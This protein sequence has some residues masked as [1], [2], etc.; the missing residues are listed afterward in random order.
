VL[1]TVTRGE[2]VVEG[3]SGARGMK[4]HEGVEGAEHDSCILLQAFIILDQIP[5]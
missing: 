2:T 3:E 1:F 4:V 5:E